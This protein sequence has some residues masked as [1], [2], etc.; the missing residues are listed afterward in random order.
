MKC[1]V[2]FDFDGTLTEKD[3]F[4]AFI[5][6]TNS[7]LK[8]ISGLIL[9]SPVLFLYKLGILSNWKAKQMVIGF[10][11]KGIEAE[12]LF[13]IG[14]NFSEQSIPG[15][16]RQNGMQKLRE[17]LASGHRV[18]IV[19]ASLQLYMEAWC[20]SIN[21]ELISTQLEINDGKITGRLD[22]KNCYGPEKAKRI[23]EKYSLDSFHKIIAYGDS[24]GD[25]EMLGI[26]HEKHFRVF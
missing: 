4:I 12:K 20:K 7:R 21:A 5:R 13:Q 6:A 26:A 17:H 25:K 23:R 18:V 24:T 15:L 9:L 10:F 11:Y 2:L 3:S 8:F 22:G 1:L 19:T 16:V 14:K